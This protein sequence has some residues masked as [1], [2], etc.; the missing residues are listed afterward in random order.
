MIGCQQ[1][2]LGKT[3]SNVS[4]FCRWYEWILFW[5][6]GPALNQSTETFAVLSRQSAV[7]VTK[8]VEPYAQLIL[9]TDIDRFGQA[10]LTHRSQPPLGVQGVVRK[11]A[12]PNVAHPWPTGVRRTNARSCWFHCLQYHR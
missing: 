5:I 11:G 2:S 1:P 10:I 8:C 4:G 7:L 9:N 3:I 6:L 12:Q